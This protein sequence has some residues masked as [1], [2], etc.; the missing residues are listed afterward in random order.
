MLLAFHR[1]KRNDHKKVRAAQGGRTE[2]FRKAQVI[3][4]E[5]RDMKTVRC[6]RDDL[7][8]GRMTR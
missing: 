8:S 6:E 4:N 7:A 5:G 1:P 2:D 3:T